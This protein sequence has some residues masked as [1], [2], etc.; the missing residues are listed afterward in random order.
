M[1]DVCI[2]MRRIE[3]YFGHSQTEVVCASTDRDLC[4]SIL[5]ELREKAK[6]RAEKNNVLSISYY[7]RSPI[8]ISSVEEFEEKCGEGWLEED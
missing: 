7:L 4:E 3:N 1:N 5:K 8:I 2:I 6:K